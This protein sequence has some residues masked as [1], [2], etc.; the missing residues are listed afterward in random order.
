[1]MNELCEYTYDVSP[2]FG[3]II[4]VLARKYRCVF[5]LQGQGD[6]EVLVGIMLYGG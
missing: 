4:V 1:M 2:V 5:L 6:S 3:K